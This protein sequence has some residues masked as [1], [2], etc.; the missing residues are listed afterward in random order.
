MRSAAPAIAA[1]LALLAPAGPAFAA[2]GAAEAATFATY[3]E[4]LDVVVSAY[5]ARE[6]ALAAW[7]RSRGLDAEA[8]KALA[9]AE[10]ASPGRDPE[11][12]AS[13]AG[14]GDLKARLRHLREATADDYLFLAQ[15]CLDRDRLF[16]ARRSLGKALA[17]NGETPQ[18]ARLLREKSLKADFLLPSPADGTDRILYAGRWIPRE[19]FLEEGLRKARRKGEA[20]SRRHGLSFEADFLPGIEFYHTLPPETMAPVK[21]AVSAYLDAVRG[22][23]FLSDPARPVRVYLLRTEEELRATGQNPYQ[24]GSYVWGEGEAYVLVETFGTGALLHELT[25]AMLDA[26]FSGMPP[27]WMNEGLACFFEAGEPGVV[28]GRDLLY[29]KAVREG[30]ARSLETLVR[31]CVLDIDFQGYGQ[32]RALMNH[33][34]SLGQLEAFVVSA[35]LVEKPSAYRGA[36]SMADH[37]AGALRHVL[38]KTLDEIGRDLEAFARDLDEDGAKIPRGLRPDDAEDVGMNPDFGNE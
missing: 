32:A 17:W 31:D 15:W 23:F 1:F 14:A 30:S 34:W 22:R 16:E 10:A 4:R 19:A 8:A 38:G 13:P 20:E 12:A 35:Q 6:R 18:A 9:R 25:H 11:L 5:A 21:A 7:C 37:Y 28:N 29:A 26:A 36:R 27:L 3:L 33:L 2:E 24:G